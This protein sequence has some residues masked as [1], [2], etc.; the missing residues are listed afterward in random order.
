MRAPFSI[1]AVAWCSVFINAGARVG[2]M[3]RRVFVGV[4][5]T[6]AG[7]VT[8]SQTAD[9]QSVSRFYSGKTITMVVGSDVGGGYDLTARTVARHLGRHI[10]G[11]PAIVVQNR[12][13]AG[14][15]LAS[16]Y[17]YEIA[18][19]DGTV[20]GAVQRPIPFQV[21]FGDAGVRFDV[22][23]MQWIGST[24]NELGVLV[25]W[26]TA[27][28]QSIDD[29]FKREMVVGG[30]GVSA[31]T[32][33]L[34]R[35]MNNVL[36]TRFKIVGGYKGQAQIVLAM[37][38]GEVHGTAN[39]SFSDIEKGHAD[40]LRDRKIR[41]LLQ[42]GLTRSESPVL[43]DVPLIMDI[44]RSDEQRSV[45]RILMGMK[46]MGRPFFV[47]P[48]VPK[49]RADALRTAFMETMRDP[50]FL[51][52]AAKTLGDIDPMSGPEMQQIIAE[53]QALPAEV[54]AKARDSMRV[55]GP[56]N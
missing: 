39:W 40:W 37:Q 7:A 54:I 33:F 53:V 29:L 43:R 27:P 8:C 20:I 10:P 18:P 16:N 56:T 24:T 49:D 17:V 15:I 13:G 44:G 26:H 12:P 22:R 42:L 46:A 9:A 19:G 47:A 14:A 34:P 21:L 4:L 5:Y 32:E 45:F 2:I 52:E 23:K 35:A 6:C 51:A 31:D 36:G 41:I 48:G 38:R 25:A 3:I 50:N 11:N 30:S 28:H 55:P 1:H